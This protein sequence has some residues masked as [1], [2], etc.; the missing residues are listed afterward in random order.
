MWTHSSTKNIV[1]THLLCDEHGKQQTER[2]SS[3]LNKQRSS[4]QD[5]HSN[6]LREPEMEGTECLVLKSEVLNKD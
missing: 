6:E 1:V 3:V 2:C 4:S 5:L